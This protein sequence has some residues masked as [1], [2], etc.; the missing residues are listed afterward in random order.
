MDFFFS[1]SLMYILQSSLHELVVEE[2]VASS[3]PLPPWWRH[4]FVPLDFRNSKQQQYR[5]QNERYSLHWNISPPWRLPQSCCACYS[6]G[7]DM[8]DDTKTFFLAAYTA[9]TSTCVESY[10]NVFPICVLWN[11]KLMNLFRWEIEP[12]RACTFIRA[13]LALITS[14]AL[15]AS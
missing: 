9:S 13:W 1:K 2:S 10:N 4:S 14:C 7:I 3:H 8:V 15:C 12:P 11:F 5:V 6:I